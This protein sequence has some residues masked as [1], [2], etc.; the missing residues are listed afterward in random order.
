MKKIFCA[1]LTLSIL[2]GCM[3]VLT[4]PVYAAKPKAP[5]SVTYELKNDT[6]GFA[7]G[8]IVVTVEASETTGKEVLIFWG[9]NGAK[10]N[11]YSYLAKH[12][13]TAA[14]TKVSIAPGILIPPGAEQILVYVR[15]IDGSGITTKPFTVDL[16]E[17]AAT[18]DFGEAVAEFQVVSDI[19][20]T[21]ETG[22]RYVNYSKHYQN[23]L[24][25]VVSK[26]GDKS[27]GIII[28]GDITQNGIPEEYR[29][30]KSLTEEV[31]GAPDLYLSVGNHDV[32]GVWRDLMTMEQSDKLFLGFTQLPDGSKPTDTSYDFWLGGYHFIILSTDTFS[33]LNATFKRST[34]N[35]LDEKLAEN[36]DPTRPSFV[37]VH[38]TI[39]NTVGGSYPEQTDF[40]TNDRTGVMNWV[41]LK[42]VLAKYESAMVFTSHSHW[43]MY[44]GTSMF[45]EEDQPYYFNTAAVAYICDDY[46][47]VTG[48]SK[49]DESQGY[50]IYIYDD[51]TVIRGYD[52]VK[53]VWISGAQFAVQYK[54]YVPPVETTTAAT[55]VAAVETTPAPQTT[56]AE[57]KS[58]CGSSVVMALPFTTLAVTAGACVSVRRRKK[59]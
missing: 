9:K 13:I 29:L 16:P 4:L 32:W 40:D 54:E 43:S 23:M 34:L 5:L 39:R 14:E 12:K 6:D 51:R 49:Y 17:N 24:K 30:M 38:Q 27:L 48:E 44:S 10:L 2:I 21:T 59:K 1:L 47:K 20:V 50:F 35:W 11:G 18:R 33:T 28:N 42:E 19:H 56:A 52:F 57:E 46:N 25:S 55:T 37:F 41:Q 45:T 26:S 31:E 36:Y 3:S 53:N 7:E 8:D 58:G 22:S 15:N